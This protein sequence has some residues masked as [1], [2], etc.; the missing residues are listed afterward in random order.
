MRPEQ[1]SGKILAKLR[2]RVKFSSTKVAFSFGTLKL[3]SVEK[4]TERTNGEE[5]RANNPQINYLKLIQLQFGL[6]I[7]FGFVYFGWFLEANAFLFVSKH[8]NQTQ[9]K[10]KLVL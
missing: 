7:V 9:M 8:K 1:K 5:W 3:N 4:H 10:R 2:E 6:Q